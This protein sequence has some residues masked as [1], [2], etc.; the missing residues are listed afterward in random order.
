M[1]RPR[2]ASSSVDNWIFILFLFL[3]C[4]LFSFLHK[5]QRRNKNRQGR[6]TWLGEPKCCWRLGWCCW[7]IGATWIGY[8]NCIDDD[9][10]WTWESHR[11]QQA[12]YVTR[13]IH[14]DSEAREAE[15]EF[16]QLSQ[17]IIERNLGKCFAHAL[18]FLWA[19]IRGRKF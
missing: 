11:F 9:N 5:I 7:W 14:N 6:K 19:S 4:F 16:L 12:F 17:S 13:H 18:P 8:C 1:C 15:A 10:V 2:T 3:R